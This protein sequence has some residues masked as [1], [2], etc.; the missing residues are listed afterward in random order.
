[1]LDQQAAT[2]HHRGMLKALIE[3]KTRQT[4]V[5][6]QIADLIEQA[7]LSGIID[8]DTQDLHICG[9]TP[10][11]RPFTEG[12]SK[13][14]FCL[15]EGRP[16]QRYLGHTVHLPTRERPAAS[17]ILLSLAEIPVGRALVGP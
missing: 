6:D 1:M 12:W 10:I 9:F 15:H 16:A 11:V 8:G 14:S 17:S 13:N 4:E 7:Y 5:E 3:Y 2:G